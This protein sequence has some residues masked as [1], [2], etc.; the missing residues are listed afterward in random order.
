VSGYGLEVET[1]SGSGIPVTGRGRAVSRCGQAE[2]RQ[3]RA[4]GAFDSH[5][6]SYGRVTGRVVFP[7]YLCASTPE[8]STSHAIPA[9]Y[10]AFVRAS[11]H[12]GL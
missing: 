7:S 3:G 2:I 11:R 1:K 12:C 9:F 8:P 6:R 10:H 5:A 4:S